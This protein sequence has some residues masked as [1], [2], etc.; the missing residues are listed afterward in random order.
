MT[1]HQ[2]VTHQYLSQFPFHLG[3]GQLLCL[4]VMSHYSSAALWLLLAISI[5]DILFYERVS[6]GFLVVD[7]TLWATADP[8]GLILH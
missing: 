5:L 8:E 6:Q 1:H 4:V 2:L 3:L 7:M